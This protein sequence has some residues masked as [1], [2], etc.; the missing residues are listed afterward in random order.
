MAHFN[1]SNL[2]IIV[3]DEGMQV[4]AI[5]NNVTKNEKWHFLNRQKNKIENMVFWEGR[6]MPWHVRH[7][8]II[9]K[10]LS[11][12]SIIIYSSPSLTHFTNSF[13]YF[14]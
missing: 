12:I 7:N 10:K 9:K 1:L 8:L 14:G 2:L 4:E 6:K 13:L 11:T 5:K 3:A